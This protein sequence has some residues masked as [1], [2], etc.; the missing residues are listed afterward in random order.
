MIAAIVLA[1]YLIGFVIY[2]TKKDYILFYFIGWSVFAPYVASFVTMDYDVSLF[3]DGQSNYFL[4][5]IFIINN[6]K[7]NSFFI[8]PSATRLV[9]A[10]FFFLMLAGLL[11]SVPVPFYLSW[12][13]SNIL[14]IYF[15]VSILGSIDITTKL[16]NRFLLILMLIQIAVGMFQY[17]TGLFVNPAYALKNFAALYDNILTGTFRGENN[18]MA[19]VCIC[20]MVLLVNYRNGQSIRKIFALF[21]VAAVS[22]TVLISGVRTY[23]ILLIF[24]AAMIIYLTS[25]RKAISLA[26]LAGGLLVISTYLIVADYTSGRGG[27]TNAI[28]RQI[29]GISAVA[30]NDTDGSTLDYTL[31]MLEKHYH[32]MDVFGQ[33]KLHTKRG[34]DRITMGTGTE[35]SVS[36]ATLAVFL[37]EFGPILLL[38]FLCYYYQLTCRQFKINGSRFYKYSI[39][40]YSFYLIAAVTDAGVF[41]VMI[42]T[43]LAMFSDTQRKVV[44]ADRC[45]S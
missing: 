23:L 42:L 15:V 14:P 45:V 33:G 4:A 12:F 29:N 1:L 28:E 19:F 40:I 7:N 5:L 34:Y 32:V 17:Y 24:Y 31:Y 43:I 30:H 11:N 2:F 36:D 26:V 25:K 10:I 20:F 18:C 27:D 9:I 21:L 13:I 41:D 44:L 3:V 37:V 38:L 6:C 16:L 22:F 39:L 35:A 8:S